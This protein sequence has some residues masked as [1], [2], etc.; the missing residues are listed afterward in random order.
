MT[1]PAAVVS[2]LQKIIT[3]VTGTTSSAATLTPPQAPERA[4]GLS[5]ELWVF[6]LQ[7]EQVLTVVNGL[8]LPSTVHAAETLLAVHDEAEDIR[9]REF[10]PSAFGYGEIAQLA[11]RVRRG[12]ETLAVAAPLIV[13][14]ARFAV[15]SQW[16]DAAAT[17][18]VAAASDALRTYVRAVAEAWATGQPATGTLRAADEQL[19]TLPA[20]IRKAYL[21]NGLDAAIAALRP[22]R[23]DL[24]GIVGDN[25]PL[26]PHS[27]G[28]VSITA[29][30]HGEQGE[31]QV[32]TDLTAE[33]VGIRGAIG[34]TPEQTQAKIDKV[35][36]KIQALHLTLVA[37]A[38]YQQMEMV[39]TQF[40]VNTGASQRLQ[41]NHTT[42]GT[43]LD[44]LHTGYA[45]GGAA[46]VQGANA[47]AR[48]LNDAQFRADFD[49]AVRQ[50]SQIK[51]VETVVLTTA[52]VTAAAL[53]GG[54]AA[55]AAETMIGAVGGDVLFAGL[56]TWA[57]VGGFAAEVITFT[58]VDRAGRTLLFGPESTG[59]TSF[60]ED[61]FWNTITMGV[62][63]VVSKGYG[64]IFRE[65]NAKSWRF[66]AGN[67][68]ADQITLFAIGQVQTQVKTGHAMGLSETEQSLA[69]QIAMALLMGLGAKIS[70]S[71][72]VRLGDT[73][74]AA[75][76]A[77]LEIAEQGAADLAGLLD[78]I[79]NNQATPEERASLSAKVEAQFNAEAE[80]V[81]QLPDGTDGKPD[82]IAGYRTMTT[83][84][85]VRAAVAGLETS[86]SGP[87]SESSAAP[88]GP[89]IIVF[90][91]SALDAIGKVMA[92]KGASEVA[93]SP[94]TD[95]AKQA[96]LPNGQLLTFI[97]AAEAK[98]A[99]RSR[100]RW[101]SRRSSSTTRSPPTAP[102]SRSAWS[103]TVPTSV[104]PTSSPGSK[105]WR[106]TVSS[107]A[108]RRL[109]G[110][111]SSGS[112]AIRNSSLGRASSSPATSSR[113]VS[114]RRRARSGTSTA[115]LSPK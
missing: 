115:R 70:T 73:A 102:R 65:V 58:I 72:R 60:K 7:L 45:A 69:Q 59:S 46:Y 33:V 61:L 25:P 44:Q 108:Y 29:M 42:L 78:K 16:L 96:K 28:D 84:L 100:Q 103:A 13:S 98:T 80:L 79:Q 109:S 6:A 1:F 85:E 66:R 111:R 105:A 2:P 26:V 77:N 95:G 15:P 54:M 62:L 43:A 18:I 86:V 106:S 55:A 11:G 37:L 31:W 97:P 81:R 75:N 24:H 112:R 35:A 27:Y 49:A 64:A 20:T 30:P 82:L 93:D 104:W 89:G 21:R 12:A 9:D 87:G 8:A 76:Q 113:S 68:A 3:L 10:G 57:E 32:T 94:V 114:A 74:P 83:E 91:P 107:R 110:W 52:I 23:D 39:F 36:R 88:A 22:H 99:R 48:L 51:F 40:P 90:A 4:L 50:L 56:T 19:R 17:P 53:T 63:R 47:V 67:I 38:M 14:A 41:A 101:S 5:D 71:V 34:D 92:E